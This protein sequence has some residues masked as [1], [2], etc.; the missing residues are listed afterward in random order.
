MTTQNRRR[1]LWTTVVETNGLQM[2]DASSP[3]IASNLL[4]TYETDYGKAQDVT[5]AAVLGQISFSASS[6]IASVASSGSVGIG[7][8]VVN[9]ET[10]GLP[11]GSS[12]IPNPLTPSQESAWWWRWVTPRLFSQPSVQPVSLQYPYTPTSESQIGINIRSQRIIR[13][14]N[15]PVLTIAV[16]GFSNVHEPMIR[17]FFRTL[18]LLP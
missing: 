11:A 3:L 12:S 10:A 16:T 7:F 15:L 6:E 4:A 5:I 2:L 1:R 8:S 18:V 17:Y 9:R 14:G 13:A